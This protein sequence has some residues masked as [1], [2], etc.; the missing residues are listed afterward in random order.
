VDVQSALIES[1]VKFYP[2]ASIEALWK[3]ALDALTSRSTSAITI[4]APGFDGQTSSGIALSGPD[5]IANFI[6]ACKA[7]IKQINGDTTTDSSNLG[8]GVSF[9]RRYLQ[10]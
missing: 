5:E 4:N 6:G 7:A 10:V 8:T 9:G 1:L 2:V 3:Q